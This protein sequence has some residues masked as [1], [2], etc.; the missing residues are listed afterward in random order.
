MKIYLGADHGGFE[1]KEKIKK[2]LTEQQYEVVDCGALALD[3]ED[4]YPDFTFAV[5]EK[6]R[7]IRSSD[8]ATIIDSADARG[9]LFCRSGAG[10]TIAANKVPGIRAATLSNTVVAKHA[11]ED[12]NINV[13]SIA[14]DWLDEVQV[15]EIVTAFLETPFSQGE[16]HVR[17]LEKITQYEQNLELRT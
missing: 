14:A 3:P 4:D 13:A 2:W 16:R 17:R 9:I 15:K 10:V 8:N 6:V 1:L 12:N 7:G 11:R 5:A